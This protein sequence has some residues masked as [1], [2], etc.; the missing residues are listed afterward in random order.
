[1]LLSSVT[2]VV[3]LRVMLTHGATAKTKE[4]DMLKAAVEAAMKG[5]RRPM[6]VSEIAEAAV[7]LAGVKGKTPKQQVYSLLY[8]ENRKDG[9]LVTR[10]DKGTFRLRPRG[11]KV[12][13]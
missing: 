8:T 6:T 11:A 5:K 12:K 9:G 3:M 7:P 10:V 1:M 2:T 13:A 4:H